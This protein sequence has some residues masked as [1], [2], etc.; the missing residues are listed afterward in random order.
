MKRHQ[1]II[2][3][4]NHRTRFCSHLRHYFSPAEKN[5]QKSHS[6]IYLLPYL[7]LLPKE[8]SSQHNNPNQGQGEHL[9]LG[10]KGN[11]W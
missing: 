4:L 10:K 6:P 5:S 1:N 11:T 2:F 8:A 9:Q 3:C 7:Q